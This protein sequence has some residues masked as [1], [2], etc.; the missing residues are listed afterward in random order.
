MLTREIA[1]GQTDRTADVLPLEASIISRLQAGD[2]TAFDEI[3]NLY[4]DMVF[5]LGFRLLGE[6]EE[7]L[8]LSQEVFLTIYRNIGT[9]RGECQLKTW[10][11]RIVINRAANRSRWWRRHKKDM[12]LSLD[13]MPGEPESKQILKSLPSQERNPYEG[14]YSLEIEDRIQQALQALPIEQRAAIIMRDLEGLSYE[15]IAESTRVSLG[16]VK[17]RIARGRE[18]LR[19]RLGGLVK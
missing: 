15:E 12:T 8:D 14:V 13:H 5:R 3:F 17:S 10:I 16:T 9:F 19:K 1:I 6:R 2:M 7:A 18:E 4:K 11:Y